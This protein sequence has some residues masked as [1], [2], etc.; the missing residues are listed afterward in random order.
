MLSCET[1]KITA[2]SAQ[3]RFTLDL[4][5]ASPGHKSATLL[6]LSPDFRTRKIS[7]GKKGPEFGMSVSEYLKTDI[8]ISGS[9]WPG[10]L[11]SFVFLAWFKK[12]T[13]WVALRVGG[14]YRWFCLT[15][16]ISSV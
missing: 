9:F 15:V 2:K 1:F 12:G 11:D 13:F 6:T 10:T 8:P 16:S 5:S 4:L 3:N 7:D 14:S